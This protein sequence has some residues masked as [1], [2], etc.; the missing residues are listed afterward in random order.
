MSNYAKFGLPNVD[1]EIINLGFGAMGLSAF[2]GAVDSLPEQRAVLERAISIGCT[3]FNT[4][5]MYRYFVSLD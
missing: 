3:T 4:A 2:Y 1:G 5:D